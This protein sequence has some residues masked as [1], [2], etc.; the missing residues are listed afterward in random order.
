MAVALQPAGPE[1]PRPG[2]LATAGLTHPCAPGW[3]IL[4][5]RWPD[6]HP[7]LGHRY[8]PVVGDDSH[9]SHLLGFLACG[10]WQTNGPEG[11]RH[12]RRPT[13]RRRDPRIVGPRARLAY[14]YG[15]S[16]GKFLSCE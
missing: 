12:V 5:R 10:R 11:R 15:A 4:L 8:W 1:H 7:E 14:T 13:A 6:P 9:R 16:R 3:P 2:A